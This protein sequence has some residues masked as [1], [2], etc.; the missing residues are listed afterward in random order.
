MKFSYKKWRNKLPFRY[1]HLWDKLTLRHMKDCNTI[2]DIGCGLG[3]FISL[4][5]AR[6]TGL[7]S[8]PDTVTFCQEKGYNC[9]SGSATALPFNDS[10]IEGIN[11]AH[12]IEHFLPI[13]AYKV[14]K[15]MDRVLVHGGILCLRTPLL[16]NH[17]YDDFTHI[18]PYN[19]EAIQHY[20]EKHDV[21]S[22]TYIPIK[23]VYETLVIKYRRAL[24]SGSLKRNAYI[25]I[26]RKLNR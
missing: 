17:F 21:R 6:I 10:S 1:S 7:D 11:C 24:K 5:P 8:N 25:M 23:S 22:A 2:L 14:L 13:D 16:W 4:D 3:E 26:M 9:I 18:K 20:L 15:E 19:P 12:V